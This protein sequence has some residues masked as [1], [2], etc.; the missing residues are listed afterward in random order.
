VSSSVSRTKKGHEQDRLA[1]PTRTVLA[2]TS[3]GRLIATF[4]S[5]GSRLGRK[6]MAKA[7]KT[8]EASDDG[9]N[10]GARML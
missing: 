2:S 3:V 7:E 10:D 4:V 8:N 1:P 6:N 9:K 5:E